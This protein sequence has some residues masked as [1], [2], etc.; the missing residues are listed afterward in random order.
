M[1]DRLVNEFIGPIVK[2]YHAMLWITHPWFSSI[3]SCGAVEQ[4]QFDTIKW[5]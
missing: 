4:L 5:S 3:F 1:G 2:T